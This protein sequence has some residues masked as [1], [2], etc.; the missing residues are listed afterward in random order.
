MLLL[1]FHSVT[2]FVFLRLTGAV[3]VVGGGGTVFRLVDRMDDDDG[4]DA[5]NKKY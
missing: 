5:S 2:T 4:S 1:S 3:I